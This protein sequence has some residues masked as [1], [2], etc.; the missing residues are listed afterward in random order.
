M[1][2]LRQFCIILSVTCAGE[3]LHAFIPL[4]VPGSIYGLVLMFL[5]LTCH[6]IPL[7]EVRETAQFLIEI[8]PVMFIP[9]A[10]GLLESLDALRPMLLPVCVITFLTTVIVMGVTGRAA[11]ALIRRN[12]KR[13]TDHE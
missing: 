6:V 3:I 1:R 9:A 8:M 4:P 11:Q 5:L 13:G 10:V 2:Y 7:Q 12:R